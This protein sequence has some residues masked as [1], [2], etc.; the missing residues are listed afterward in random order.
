VFSGGRVS[1]Q[2][3]IKSG[4]I[5]L[6]ALMAEKYSGVAACS[7]KSEWSV[8]ANASQPWSMASCTTSS[9]EYPP[10][11]KRVWV[12]VSTTSGRETSAHGISVSTSA[13][14]CCAHPPGSNR[15]V[16]RRLTRGISGF[17]GGKPVSL[18]YQSVHTGIRLVARK[19]YVSTKALS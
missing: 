9:A 18:L 1:P 11:E 17:S 13:S 4:C 19:N 8:M 3:S 10:S 15:Y 14:G 2:N 5:I 7:D 12:C 16:T 6:A